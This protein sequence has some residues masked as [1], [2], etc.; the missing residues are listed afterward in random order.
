[1]KCQNLFSWKNKKM[2]QFV[3]AENSSQHDKLGL[4]LRVLDFISSW[5]II[6]GS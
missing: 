6:S 3:V 2:F 4:N 1:M 5:G